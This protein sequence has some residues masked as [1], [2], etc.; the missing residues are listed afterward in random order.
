MAR[1]YTRARLGAPLSGPEASMAIDTRTQISEEA[2][3]RLAL[4]EPDRK[5]ELRDGASREKPGM[6][7]AHN[8]LEV[9]LGYMLM[10]QLEWSDFQ[11]RLDAGRVHRPEATYFIPDVFVVPTA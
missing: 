9:K 11:V 1:A 6:T 7:A 10:S 3:E 2:Y 4:A 8:W 5:W